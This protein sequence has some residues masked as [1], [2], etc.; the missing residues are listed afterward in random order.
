MRPP[1]AQLSTIGP[2]RRQWRA[3]SSPSAS[4]PR[5][6]KPAT[7]GW[8]LTES[9]ATSP[10]AHCPLKRFVEKPD[11]ATAQTLLAAGT[12]LWNAGIFLFSARTLLDAVKA[13]APDL[14]A[15]V[16]KPWPRRKAI[17]TSSACRPRP[18]RTLRDIS[19]DYAIMEHAQ[20]LTVVPY[21]GEWSDLGDWD[22]VWRSG[23]SDT[24]GNV[25]D[26]PVT[27]LD[28]RKHPAARRIPRSDIW[29]A[30]ALK[31][32]SSSPCR[33]P[34][35]SRIAGATQEVKQAVASAEIASRASGRNASL[36]I[37]ALGDGSKPLSSQTAFR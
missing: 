23:P 13:H 33:M 37:I 7:A 5:G 19:I 36:A 2:A 8:S 28:L 16:A 11:A 6:P 17:S 18:G 9:R 4:A 3:R 21:P 22:A 31:T 15:P 25:T 35:W 32:S 10:R 26:G 12:Y 30:S 29:S 34:F 14:L 27:A 24:A 1:F 20:N